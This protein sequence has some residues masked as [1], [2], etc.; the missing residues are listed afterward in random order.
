MTKTGSDHLKRRARQIARDTNRRFPDVLAELRGR[1]PA[2][3]RT[4]STELVPICSGLAGPFGEAGRCARPAGHHT[5][6]LLT[7]H[8]QCETEPHYPAHI[9]NG[10]F[11]A[12]SAASQ[13]E[14]EAWLAGLTPAEREEYERQAEED[15][16]AQMAADA[17]E[18]YDPYEDKYRFE[19]YEDEASMHE[20]GYGP[21]GEHG[22]DE[23]G[24]DEYEDGDDLDGDRW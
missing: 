17:A 24:D 15:H 7:R 16:W 6:D 5:L 14:H 20:G 2:S 22:E 19:E 11:E 13:A 1:R 12:R 18:P 4:P 23:D 3:P 10:Y 8:S 9:W 21:Q